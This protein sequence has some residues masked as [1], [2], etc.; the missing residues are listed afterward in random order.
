MFKLNKHNIILIILFLVSVL[1]ISY[2][3]IS[4]GQIPKEAMD[5]AKKAYKFEKWEEKVKFPE[6]EINRLDFGK[7]FYNNFSNENRILTSENDK[8]KQS[9]IT[10]KDKKTN[11][12]NIDVKFL[13]VDTPKEAHEGMLNNMA[14][15][16]HSLP[17][18][19]EYDPNDPNLVYFRNTKDSNLP[20]IG[21]IC[22]IP[23]NLWKPKNSKIPVINLLWFCRNNILVE[24]RINAPEDQREYPN[25]IE[26]AAKIDRKLISILVQK[27]SFSDK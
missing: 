18:Y 27:K 4:Q 22:F 23:I 14:Y 25:L 10:L 8:Y 2:V 3:K 24:V 7:D 12:V 11:L 5:R 17:A 15:S 20:V 16:T 6:K 1:N 26:L 19:R 9:R 13:F 21:D